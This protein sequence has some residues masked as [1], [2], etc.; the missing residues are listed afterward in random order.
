MG[1]AAVAMPDVWLPVAN[2]DGPP[3]KFAALAFRRL[4]KERSPPL[5]HF[6]ATPLC[7]PMGWTDHHQN[8][9]EEP[10]QPTQAPW[11]RRD[12]SRSSRTVVA[13]AEKDSED[14]WQK[15]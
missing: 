13:V 4:P 11:R 3:S 10:P 9:T 8:P 6:P 5:L 2:C 1:P 14:Q 12:M 15:K 7:G